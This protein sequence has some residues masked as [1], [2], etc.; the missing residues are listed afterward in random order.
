[1]KF[2]WG[3]E[4]LLRLKESGMVFETVGFKEWLQM[5]L[6]IEDDLVKNPSRKLLAFWESQNWGGLGEIK[7]DTVA[8]DATSLLLE[9]ELRAVD[10]DLMNELVAAWMKVW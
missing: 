8:D 2:S 4:F 7:F 1:M 10:R 9:M 3:K 5:M 6:E